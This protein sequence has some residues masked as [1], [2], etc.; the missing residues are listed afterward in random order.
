M[1]SFTEYGLWLQQ[2]LVPE[3]ENKEVSAIEARNGGFVLTLSGGEQIRAQ[4]VAVAVGLR[5]YQRIPESLAHLPRELLS[6]SAE[7]RSYDKFRD[8]DVCVIGAGQSALEAA[9]LLYEAGARPVLLAR[10]EVIFHGKTPE[11]RPLLE[12]IRNPVTVLGAGRL[13]WVL[14]HFPWA[15]HWLPERKRV[16]FARKY[17]GPSGAWWLRDRFEGKVPVRSRCEVI[18]ARTEDG[19]VLLRLR[20]N[21]A[22]EGLR[23]AHVVAG[24]GFE[25]DLDRLPFITQELR[26]R[27]ARVERAPRLDRHFQSSMPGLYFVGV[28]AMLSFGPIVR[29]VTGTSYCVPVVARHLQ[30]H[31]RGVA[32]PDP[33]TTASGSAAVSP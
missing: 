5:Y 26:A 22:E 28:T 17:L 9:T 20:R 10:R 24:T 25:V 8:Q 2:R 27:I 30:R 11:R 14:Q 12:R 19:G 4:R 13:N 29:F 23:V 7:C 6:H 21:G 16:P 32:A 33:G 31:S 15:V 18:S 3:V 1:E